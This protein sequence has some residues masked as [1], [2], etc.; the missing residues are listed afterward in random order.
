MENSFVT[1]NLEKYNEIY[2]K[3][4]MFDKLKEQY[5]EELEC[6]LTKLI[7]S[8][9]E[10]FNSS[11]EDESTKDDNNSDYKVGDKVLI[12]GVIAEI[13]PNDKQLTYKIETEY[14]FYCWVNKNEIYKKE[15]K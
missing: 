1:L 15:D 9:E 7:R 6:T 12:K 14:C 2:E 8:I 5:G 10:M 4:K 13:D 3:A 11:C